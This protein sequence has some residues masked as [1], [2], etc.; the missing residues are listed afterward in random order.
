[1]FIRNFFYLLLFT[2]LLVSCGSYKIFTGNLKDDVSK[3]NEVVKS[4]ELQEYLEEN[5]S[6]KFVL[7]YPE[8][9]DKYSEEDQIRMNEVFGQIEKELIKQGHTVKDRILLELLLDKGEKTL[10]EIGKAID[11]DIII[12]VIQMDFDIQN[13]VKDFQIKEFG[14]KTNF[15]SWENIEFVDCRTAM[16]ECRITM[17]EL[18]NVGGIFKFYVSG[19]DE[20]NDFYIKAYESYSGVLDN[21]KE[22]FV[23]W[24]YGNVSFTKL[25]HTYDMNEFSRNRAVG[26]LVSALLNELTYE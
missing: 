11:T 25:T 16:M 5:T 13:P 4:N 8:G 21:T 20:G 22:S 7:R 23:G 9:M 1:M 6:I 17:V 24:N 2:A 19:C 10:S 3:R 14:L 15:D 18:G 26:R 12:E